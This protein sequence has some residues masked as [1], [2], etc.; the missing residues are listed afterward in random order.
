LPP[1]RVSVETGIAAFLAGRY[2]DAV[3]LLGTTATT[4][5]QGSA[6]ARFYL[7]CSLAAL[8]LSGEREDSELVNAKATL[9]AAGRLDQFAADRRIVSPRV[10]AALGVQP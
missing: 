1:A 3:T 2:G 7:A 6:R 4:D 5:P 10:L 9:Q 8:V